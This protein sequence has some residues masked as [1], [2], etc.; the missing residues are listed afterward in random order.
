MGKLKDA[1]EVLE[2]GKRLEAKG[3]AVA[4]APTANDNG[5][6]G[7]PNFS[8]PPEGG[9][10]PEKPPAEVV[11][12]GQRLTDTGNA[13]RLVAR[14]RDQIRYCPPRK[15]WYIWD[16]RRW[17]RDEVG[18]IEQFAKATVRSIYGEA[19]KANDEG[20]RQMLAEHALKSERRER[21]NAMV[22]L[23]QS[24]P[25]IPVLPQELDADP[26][27]FNVLNGTLDLRT[28]K[29][30][31]H[32]RTQMITK[33]SHV[34][35]DPDARSELWEKYLRDATAGDDE[36]AAYLRR[37]VGYAL[38][39]NATEKQFYFLYGP[40]NGTKSTFIKA[41]A[42]AMGEYAV[43]AAFTTWLVHTSTGGNRGD[44]VSLMGARLVTSVEVR[45]NAR[46]DEEVIKKVT[47]GDVVTAAA[48][49]EAEISYVP[50]FT[51]ILAANDAPTIRDDD[52]GA[53]SRARRL[54]FTNCV[55]PEKQIAS[56]SALLSR[57]KEQ[58][59]ILAF[60]VR[61]CLEWQA[62]GGM[63]TC[64]AIERDT[65]K[66]RQEMD[67]FSAFLRDCCVI[68]AEARVAASD[69][70]RTY[71]LWCRENGQKVPMSGNDVAT[72]LRTRG[73]VRRA[74]SGARYW[75]GLRLQHD[76]E[77]PVTEPADDEFSGAAGGE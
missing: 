77:E 68:D 20:R 42:N 61:G 72:R 11:T 59:A 4:P 40:P 60:G 57:P 31:E 70:R 29:L 33:L 19:E 26:W 58:A 14:Y 38:Q 22:S 18:Q 62:Q 75:H 12:I 51:L 45:K 3:R 71:E 37:L 13:E 35:Y 73:C 64:R 63:G 5:Q 8:E 76:G 55:P 6:R 32:D 24:E 10:T 74:S 30:S 67:R 56:M 69:L 21:R 16:G 9:P 49:Y 50:S 1:C 15:C 2:A 27:A 53:W 34:Q 66:Y 43:T 28:G 65:N 44:L 39:G 36:F 46:F 54:P 52:D 17:I 47:G 23:A 41:I 48:K 25:G 7:Q